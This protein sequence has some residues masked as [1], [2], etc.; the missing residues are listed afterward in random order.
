LA[1]DNGEV[2]DANVSGV[3]HLDGC[4]WLRPT[5]FDEGLTE[6]GHFLGCGVESA[7]F[8]F[9]S[10]R[11]DKLHHLGDRENWTIVLGEGVVFKDEDVGMGSTA[12]L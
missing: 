12:A 3:V 5:Y 7:K 1:Q 11:H 9:G 4:A 10:R 2:G 6:G 8:S